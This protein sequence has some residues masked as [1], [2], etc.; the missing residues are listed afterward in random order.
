M[1]A[2][3]NLIFGGNR[4]TLVLLFCVSAIVFVSGTDFGQAHNN[5]TFREDLLQ[6]ISVDAGAASSSEVFAIE[7]PQKT[8]QLIWRVIGTDEAAPVTLLLQQNGENLA[9]IVSPETAT[10]RYQGEG[11]MLSTMAAEKAL[12]IQL[13]AKVLDRSKD[14]DGEK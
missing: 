1:I 2:K 10:D 14:K 13:Y 11:F 5:P 12:S 4:K 3:T 9:E 8:V 6:T 7:W